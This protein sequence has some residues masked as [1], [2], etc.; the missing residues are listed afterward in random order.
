[1]ELVEQIILTMKNM[2]IS[3]CNICIFIIIE[4]V[5]ILIWAYNFLKQ[6]ID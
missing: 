3:P 4:V 2:I 6:H 1:M 5:F